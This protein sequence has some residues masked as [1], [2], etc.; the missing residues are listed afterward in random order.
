MALNFLGMHPKTS[1]KVFDAQVPPGLIGV[2]I[3]SKMVVY[4]DAYRKAD[5]LLRQKKQKKSFKTQ[6]VDTIQD[7]HNIYLSKHENQVSTLPGHNVVL[8]RKLEAAVR[9]L[10]DL[11]TELNNANEVHRMTQQSLDDAH[12]ALTDYKAANAQNE[13]VYNVL[14]SRFDSI[15]V[16][17]DRI[18]ADNASLDHALSKSQAKIEDGKVTI[19]EALTAVYLEQERNRDLK[20]KLT[21]SDALLAEAKD[22]NDALEVELEAFMNADVVDAANSDADTT[23]LELSFSFSASTYELELERDMYQSQEQEALEAL[24][25]EKTIRLALEKDLQASR[26]REHQ[27]IIASEAHEQARIK[28]NKEKLKAS[29]Q[30]QAALATIAELTSALLAEE[31]DDSLFSQLSTEYTSDSLQ[32]VQ[33]ATSTKSKST[34]RPFQSINKTQSPLTSRSNAFSTD[35]GTESG[36]LGFLTA[37][38]FA[39]TPVKFA[40]PDKENLGVV[41]RTPHSIRAGGL[42]FSDPVSFPSM[43]STPA[44]DGSSPFM[45]AAT[46]ECSNAG[47]YKYFD[48]ET[49]KFLGDFENW[50]FG[51]SSPALS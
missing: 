19:G 36:F 39:N 35:F 11:Q 40:H 31:D 34:L 17:Y 23:D 4:Q 2:P 24:E 8:E 25:A 5:T 26:E 30:L 37:D 47:A 49:F 18:V 15:L 32:T 41:F 6:A 51:L 46:Q 27:A 12:H 38:L 28:A 13:T 20:K 9:Q 14:R 21:E 22:R 10:S 7:G 29:S 33:T 3:A 45:T 43:P 1:F 44:F 16:A 42:V 50:T 48:D